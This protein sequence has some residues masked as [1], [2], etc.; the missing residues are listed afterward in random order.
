MLIL[1]YLKTLKALQHASISIQIILRELVVSS[2]ESR[3][4]KI[5][6]NI[7][8]PLW[9]CGSIRLV[10]M[11]GVLCGDV[12]WT[13]Y[14]AEYGVICRTYVSQTPVQNNAVKNTQSYI[15]AHSGD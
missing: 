8:D 11:H 15:S 12:S 2:L 1:K 4:F 3:S 7:E 14:Q 10:C 9:Q 6:K 13:S 5:T